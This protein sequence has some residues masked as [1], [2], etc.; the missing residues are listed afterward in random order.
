[1]KILSYHGSPAVKHF[2]VEQARRHL[3]T[4][5]L[6]AGTYGE[7][8]GENFRA[9]SVGCMAHDID[10]TRKDFHAVVAEHAGWPEWLVRLNDAVFENLPSPERNTFHVKLREAV[11][12]GVDLEPVLHKLAIRRLDRLIAAQTKA[13]EA[14]RAYGVHEAIEKVIDA[15]GKVRA[16]HSAYSAGSATYSAGSADSAAYSADSARSAGYSADS[17]A[18]SAARSADSAA[19]SAD[20]ATY[21]AGSAYSAAYSAYSAARSAACSATYSAYSAAR[22]AAYSAYSAARS[23]D[24]AT[25][26]AAY[27]AYSAAYSAAWKQEAAD[28]LEILRAPAP[29]QGVQQ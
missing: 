3:A 25:Y 19:R 12:V 4:G 17:A 5:T 22:S 24:S 26:S 2:H 7:G 28:L 15:L 10:P 1:M 13:L 11:P 6:L 29:D 14:K 16:Y 20:S 21:S 23:A 18:Y 9:C 27:S 8:S